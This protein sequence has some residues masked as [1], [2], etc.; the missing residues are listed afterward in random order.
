MQHQYLVPRTGTNTYLPH[1]DTKILD[2]YR[3]KYIGDLEGVHWTAETYGA[4]PV[5]LV[6]ADLSD[7]DDAEIT[8]Q[9]DVFRFP[10]NNKE[11]INLAAMKAFFGANKIPA[12]Y[13]GADWNHDEAI[14]AVRKIFRMTQIIRGLQATQKGEDITLDTKFADFAP[15]MRDLFSLSPSATDSVHDMVRAVSSGFTKD[16]VK[17]DGL[18]AVE[19][20]K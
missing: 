18:G 17:S 12:D 19:A 10:D 16:D 1:G 2:V 15:V 5:F 20:V 13:L 3:P 8:S 6:T 7:F 9:S 14:A 11:P 4:A